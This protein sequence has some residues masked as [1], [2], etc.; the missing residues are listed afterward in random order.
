[1]TKYQFWAI[2]YLLTAILMAVLACIPA[3]NSIARICLEI[4]TCS[5]LLLSGRSAY[6]TSKEST[7]RDSTHFLIS[8]QRLKE[9][10]NA[11][12]ELNR[13]LDAK[14]ETVSK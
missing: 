3:L 11:E 12:F 9:M 8:E 5:H 14:A 2:Y 6:K 10:L 4:A 13:I 7:A 1:M